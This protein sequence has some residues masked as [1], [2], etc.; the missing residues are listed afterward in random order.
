MISLQEEDNVEP[1]GSHP[2]LGSSLTRPLPA[3]THHS[4]MYAPKCLVL[5]S[6]LDYIETFRVITRN[7]LTFIHVL[8]MNFIFRI[9]LV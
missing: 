4:I 1:D 8:T 2:S 9:V 7:V 3:I 5:V 6:R